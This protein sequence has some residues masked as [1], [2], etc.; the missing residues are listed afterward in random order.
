MNEKECASSVPIPIQPVGAEGILY[1]HLWRGRGS[2]LSML[3]PMPV[4][5][6]VTQAFI[7]KILNIVWCDQS[8]PNIVQK[9]RTGV[10]R[11]IN[12]M[13]TSKFIQYIYCHYLKNKR[14]NCSIHDGYCNMSYSTILEKFIIRSDMINCRR[15]LLWKKWIYKRWKM[16]WYIKQVIFD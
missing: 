3:S 5:L 14:H 4:W 12:N 9:F 2:F 16:L 6:P 11:E 10:I 15:W 8:P 7:E 13:D 1:D